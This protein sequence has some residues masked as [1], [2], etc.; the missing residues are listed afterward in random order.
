MTIPKRKTEE[1]SVVIQDDLEGMSF[2]EGIELINEM[3]KELEDLGWSNIKFDVSYRYEY[4]DMILV[5]YREETEE[6]YSIR[7]KKW[8]HQQS[9]KEAKERSLYERL[10]KKFDGKAD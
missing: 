4:C 7:L 3:K 5:G 2:D 6:A 10:K 8:E 1:H 9:E